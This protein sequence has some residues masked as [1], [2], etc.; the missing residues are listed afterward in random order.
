MNIKMTILMLGISLSACSHI[1]PSQTNSEDYL[2]IFG[3]RYFN[4]ERG[5]GSPIVVLHGLPDHSLNQQR[6]IDGLSTSHQ[7]F[8]YDRLGM[9][10]SDKPKRNY[11]IPEQTRDLEAILSFKHFEKPVLLGHSVG[12]TLAVHYA[13][14]HPEKVS[15]LVLMN[16][17]LIF[18]P[19][20]TG[21]RDFNTWLMKQ[22]L[23]GEAIM[24]MQSRSVTKA[25]LKHMF[26][27][28]TKVTEQVVDSY[29][30]P[31]QERGAKRHF[32]GTLRSLYDL[33]AD[34]F[35]SDADKI[36]NLGIPVLLVWTA[37]DP[38]MP[39]G[40]A[41][42]LAK[43]FGAKLILIQECGHVPQIELADDR[44]RREIVIPVQEFLD[45]V[46]VSEKGG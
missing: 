18:E 23:I 22:P 5:Q 25:V 2:S 36:G 37:N 32:L 28:K 3:N 30:F 35:V 1:Q 9:G 19:G 12:G 24:A 26:Y 4:I 43:R 14:T 45:E 15:A 27:D 34:V 39:L 8:A 31:F 46:K 41:Q 17:V 42:V 20:H 11:D 29:Y 40:D 10:Q 33:G 16:P 6:L 44:L 21:L 7:V 38:D 13:A